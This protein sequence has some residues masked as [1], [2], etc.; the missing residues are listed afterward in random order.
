MTQKV[1]SVLY[2]RNVCDERGNGRQVEIATVFTPLHS[3][4]RCNGSGRV[5]SGAVGS[6]PVFRVS[7]TI[8]WEQLNRPFVGF[9]IDY[10]E[11]NWDDF[12]YKRLKKRVAVAKVFTRKVQSFGYVRVTRQF[13]NYFSHNG[14]VYTI[15]PIRS[16]ATVLIFV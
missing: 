1:S 6:W 5:C 3:C 2:C 15:D 7:Y 14:C 8:K 16:V 10:S 9:S 12:H 13:F 11:Y 4:G